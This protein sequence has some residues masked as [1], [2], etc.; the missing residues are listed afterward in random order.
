[1]LIV[2][3]AAG[4]TDL[5]EVRSAQHLA[6]QKIEATRIGECPASGLNKEFR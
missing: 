6:R 5:S 2:R 4:Y 3:G 1:V